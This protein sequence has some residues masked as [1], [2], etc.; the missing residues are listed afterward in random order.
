MG[1][2]SKKKAQTSLFL[3]VLT[4]NSVGMNDLDTTSWVG[5]GYD[6]N[7]YKQKRW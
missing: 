1:S 4:S 2:L 7:F 3:S 5:N 6:G